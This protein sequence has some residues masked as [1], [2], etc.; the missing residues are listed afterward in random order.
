MSAIALDASVVNALLFH[1]PH[2]S[3]ADHVITTAIN[4]GILLIAPFLL[5]VEVTN[6]VRRRMRAERFSMATAQ[7]LLARCELLSIDLLEP[8]GLHRRA[9]DL[10]EAHSL[11][12]HDAHYVALAMIAGYDLWTADERLMRAV[13]GR[14]PFV[15]WIGDYPLPVSAPPDI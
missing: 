5:P 10:T 12:G 15:R 4:D 6:T 11:G 9:L 1:E 8:P 13:R 3:H 14:L 2:S 7:T